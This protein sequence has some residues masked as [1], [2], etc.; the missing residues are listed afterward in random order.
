MEIIC[1]RGFFE[2][3]NEQNSLI[4]FKKAFQNGF[5]IE[6]DIRD[7]NSNLVI[8]H[9]IASGNEPTLEDLFKL[10]RKLGNN[11]PLALNIKSSEL[12]KPLKKLIDT[13]KIEN[14]FLFDMTIPD[15]IKY[16]KSKD[17]KIYTRQ[18]EY[19]IE[20]HLYEKSAGVWMDEFYSHWI[21]ASCIEK[22]IKNDKKV[23]LVSPE[24]HNNERLTR[25]NIW[26]KIEQNLDC[27]LSICV[28]YPREAD[29]YFNN[30]A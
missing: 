21:N 1:H 7:Y 6:T 28:N 5:G 17:I 22:H 15:A 14:Y 30:T 9:E 11:L 4:S 10:Y 23:V 27:N 8:S 13:Y 18:S 19:E 29:V 12:Q 3:K 25:W 16:L 26:K 20:P 24:L 2:F